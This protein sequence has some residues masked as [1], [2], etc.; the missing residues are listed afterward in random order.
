MKSLV[1]VGLAALL[2]STFTRADDPTAQ[3]AASA[4]TPKSDDHSSR[5]QERITKRYAQ[6]RAEYEALQ[7][8]IREAI[9]AG[10]PRDKPAFAMNGPARHTYYCRRMIELAESS[11]A[12]PGARD[13]LLWV[14]DAPWRGDMGAYHDEFSRAAA[15]LVRYH[16]N[17]PEA[18]RIGLRLDNVLNPGRDAVLFGF[19]SAA[20]DR[21]AKGLARLAL[22][23]Y[24][25]EKSRGG[26]P[27]PQ[28]RGPAQA[29]PPA[30]RQSRSRVRSDQR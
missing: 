14:L 26:R 21:E 18:V 8:S 13:A 23:Q 30:R 10:S 12:D 2:I 27:G 20:K 5:P 6:I 15:L 11:P 29:P 28:C 17:D 22:A 16:G 24:L 3:A 9:K 19:Y 25:K 1:S 4:K 7:A